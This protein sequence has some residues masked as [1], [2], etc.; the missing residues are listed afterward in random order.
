MKNEDSGYELRNPFFNGYVGKRNITFIRG[1]E[2]NYD[3]INIFRDV[4]DYLSFMTQ[5]NDEKMKD[6]TIILHSLN[7]LRDGVAF[8]KG[9]GYRTAYT[10]MDNNEAGRKAILSWNEFCA[11]E[12]SLVHHPMNDLYE[13]FETVNEAHINKVNLSLKAGVQ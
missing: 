9:F 11:K 8:I 4:F 3:G 13:N 2:N 12:Q 10:W 6:D 7:C 1:T 5:R